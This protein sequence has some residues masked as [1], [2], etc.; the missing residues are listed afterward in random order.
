M[1]RHVAAA[2][3]GVLYVG[4]AAWLVRQEGASHRE[5]LR[6][7]RLAL[8]AKSAP[9]PAAVPAPPIPPAPAETGPP[10][11]E[12]SK[13][14]ALAPVPK[15]G[16]TS[17]SPPPA[18]PAAS[19]AAAGTNAN[20]SPA[21]PPRVIP[22]EV[23]AWVKALDLEKLKPADEFRLG[24]EL[25]SLA[26]LATPADQAGTR[27][28]RLANLARPLLE[29]RTRKDIPYRFAILASDEVSAFSL[30]GGYINLCRG[31][32][33]MVGEDEDYV[34][35]FLIAHEIAHV[36]LR[37]DVRCVKGLL[38]STKQPQALSQFLFPIVAGYPDEQE[39]EADAWA[40]K[41]V[42]ALHEGS[43]RKSSAFLRKLRD[44]AE[45]RGFLDGRKTS[46]DGLNPFENHLR[47]HPAVYERL[48]RL[49]KLRESS[50]ASPGA[51]PKP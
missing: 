1:T 3:V 18:V 50:A 47:T 43:W 15:A 23:V 45:P 22:D 32:F 20:A 16:V 34:L 12:V 7:E 39:F 10:M 35:Q 19:K 33:D 14:T 6:Q 51:T 37:H 9:P 4:A 31:T 42:S 26:L 27:L 46:T 25:Q 49:E 38:K 13:A 48:A 41:Q 5:A 28:E 29:A 2:I 21:P 8:V 24:G 11:P 17:T 30:P 36:D 40:Y 44:Y